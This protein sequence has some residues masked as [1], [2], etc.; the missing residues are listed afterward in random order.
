MSH[1]K[2]GGEN[3]HEIV[4]FE[5]I[6]GIYYFL[7]NHCKIVPGQASC[8]ICHHLAAKVGSDKIHLLLYIL[9]L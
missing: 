6:S 3:K 2:H 7:K 5:M 9:S 1:R 8:D 4:V